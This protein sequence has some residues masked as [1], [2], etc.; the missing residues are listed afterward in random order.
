MHILTLENEVI[1]GPHDVIPAGSYLSENMNG[2]QLLTRAGGGTMQVFDRSDRLAMMPAIYAGKKILVMRVGGFGDLVLLTPVLREIKR[3]LSD[4]EIHVSCMGHYGQVLQGLPYV[5]KVVPYPLP[6]EMVSGYVATIFLEDAIEKSALARKLHM[7]E[8]FAKLCGIAAPEDMIP[9]YRVS[10]NESVWASE[11]FP[12]VNGTQRACIQVGASAL[13]RVY[14]R[15][16]MGDVVGRMLKRGWEVFLMGAKGEVQTP[17]GAPPKLRNLSELNLTMRQSAAVV[18]ACDVFIG[19]DSAL[20]HIAGALQVPAV[21]LY[22][23][24]PWRLRTAYCPTTHA[25]TGKGECAPCFHH[26]NPAL[27]NHFPENCPGAKNSQCA[28]LAEIKPETVVSKA[29][30][31][32][33]KQPT[34][35]PDSPRA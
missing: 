35:P 11:M 26:S 31:M 13:C 17:K 18:N 16:L 34:T 22:G 27:R 21:G 1:L 30:S 25:L 20:L 23:P 6:F 15:N 10:E 3:L 24:F 29:E 33:R 4:T 2:A 5:D 12:R 19:N 32:S 7:T 14:P 9:D 8:L 28:V